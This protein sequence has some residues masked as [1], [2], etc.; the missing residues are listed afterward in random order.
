MTVRE[1][2]CRCGQLRAKCTGDPIRV[3]V[4]HCLECQ[5]RS[6]SVFATQARW[7]NERL[8]LTGEFSEWSQVS[9]SGMRATFRFCAVCGAT[10]AYESEGMPG[11]TAIAVGAFA[12]P[13]FPPPKFSVYEERKHPWTAVLGDDVE[14]LD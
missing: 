1:A 4:C 5:K 10:V 12:D 3:S 2:T 7:P 9:D 13:S 11:M 6:G 8:E 14:H